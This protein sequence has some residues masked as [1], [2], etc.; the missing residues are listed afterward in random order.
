MGRKGEGGRGRV[1][2]SGRNDTA[3]FYYGY[4]LPQGLSSGRLNSWFVA[5]GSGSMQP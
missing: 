2:R 3:D 4:F 5:D 1:D